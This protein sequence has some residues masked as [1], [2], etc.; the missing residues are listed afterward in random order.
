MLGQKRVRGALIQVG[1][2]AQDVEEG[3]SV[4]AP[5]ELSV[6]GLGG[7]SQVGLGCVYVCVV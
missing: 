1:R 5:V 4:E 6:D 7:D 3:V 2:T